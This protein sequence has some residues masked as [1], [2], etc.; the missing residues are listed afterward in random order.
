MEAVEKQQ[1]HKWYPGKKL[2][3]GYLLCQTAQSRQ[4]YSKHG[5]GGRDLSWGFPFRLANAFCIVSMFHPKLDSVV[6]F[7]LSVC[8]YTNMERVGQ[9]GQCGLP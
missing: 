3:L 1:N 5:G 6:S 7:Y 2:N 9:G 4:L 8:P